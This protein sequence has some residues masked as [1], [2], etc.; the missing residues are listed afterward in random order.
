MRR[1]IQILHERWRNIV[2]VEDG[3]QI[4]PLS[5][6]FRRVRLCVNTGKVAAARVGV[7]IALEQSH[8]DLFGIV[9]FDDE[10]QQEDLETLFASLRTGQANVVIGNR[11]GFAANSAMPL[12][13]I[14]VNEVN[15]LVSASFGLDIV[16]ITSGMVACDRR[17]ASLFVT[18]SRSSR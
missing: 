16:D 9:D 10:Q 12:H 18:K 17:F 3:S 4:V 1:C 2:V 7:S 13:R 15:R 11:Y 14:L 8:A 6:D 5:D